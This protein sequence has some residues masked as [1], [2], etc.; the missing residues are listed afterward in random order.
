MKIIFLY[1]NKREIKQSE[2]ENFEWNT[3][4]GMRMVNREDKIAKQKQDNIMQG[5]NTK[6]KY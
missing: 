1:R 3:K 4:F 6:V 5:W 2:R